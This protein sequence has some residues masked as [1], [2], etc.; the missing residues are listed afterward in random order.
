MWSLELQAIADEGG[1][2]SL[3][4]H[5][6]LSGRGARLRTLEQLIEMMKSLGVWIATA[7]EVARHVG[8]LGLA[9]RSFPQPILD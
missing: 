2:F 6:F 9:P 4:N 5:P 3:T 8:T 7:G 1:C